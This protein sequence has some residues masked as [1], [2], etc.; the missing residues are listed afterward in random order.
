MLKYILKSKFIIFIE[1]TFSSLFTVSTAFI[2]F[3]S[4]LLFDNLV[5][6]GVRYLIWLVFM[7]LLCMVGIFVFQY[8]SQVY[9]WKR[10]RHF[11]VL[12]KADYFKQLLKHDYT[13][14]SKK[15][16]PEYISI[17]QNDVNVLSA[18][19]V[20]GIIEIAKAIMMLLVYGFFLVI[21]VDY[22]IALAIL[23]ASIISILI[24][25]FFGDRLSQRQKKHLT[26]AGAYFNKLSD[27]LSGFKHVN[28]STKQAMVKE[29]LVALNAFVMN[30]VSLTA[31]IW[32]HT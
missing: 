11:Q 26:L 1:I 5:N 24:P 20:E 21:F 12:L 13:L 19:Y 9:S 3:L 25:R 16:I 23:I 31:F 15:T 17:F 30:I 10:E 18:E 2:P 27:L 14:F 8:L 4:I 29:H 7:Y 6:E 32:T 28:N 22:R